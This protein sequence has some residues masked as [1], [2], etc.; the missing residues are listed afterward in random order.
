M[1]VGGGVGCRFALT[2]GD[3]IDGIDTTEKTSSDFGVVLMSSQG[4]DFCIPS[5]LET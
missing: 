3:I 5:S 4:L 2:L 1:D